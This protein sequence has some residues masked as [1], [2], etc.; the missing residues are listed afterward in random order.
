M[1][2]ETKKCSSQSDNK[3]I[4]LWVTYNY[5]KHQESIPT[6]QENTSV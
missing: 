6:S 2:L 3:K 4:E 5:E 1:G